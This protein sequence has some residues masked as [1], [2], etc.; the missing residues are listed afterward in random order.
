MLYLI[1]LVKFT[2]NFNNCTITEPSPYIVEGQQNMPLT[3]NL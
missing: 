2:T 3:F 1:A